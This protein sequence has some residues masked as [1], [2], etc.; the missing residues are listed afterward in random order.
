MTERR[1]LGELGVSAQGLGCMGMSEFY[2]GRM[3]LVIFIGLPAAG[4][5]S[6]YRQRFAGT[7][8]HVSKDL[9]PR[10]AR[11]KQVRQLEEIERALDTGTS[12]VVD[13]TSPRPAD[14]AALIELAHRHGGRA[15]AYYF[16]PKV[17]ESIRRNAERNPQVP[18]VAIFTTAKRLQP[19][20]FE[21]GFDEIHEVRIE[22]GGGFSVVQRGR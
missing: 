19:P 17:N 15:V 7:H 2:A 3:D 4:K 12:V 10:A 22:A 9:M 8:A 16:Q 18:K 14:R 1:K 11:D 13:N 20:S 5:T 21:E 6:F